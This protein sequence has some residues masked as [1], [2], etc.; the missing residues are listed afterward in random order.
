MEN[1]KETGGY[2]K[3]FKIVLIVLS[4]F[5]AVKMLFFAFG[6][7]EEY[8]LVMAY[9]HIK[10]DKLFLDM[11][12]PHQSSAFLCELLMRPYL[13]VCGK[14]GV[15]IW[16]RF[17]GTLIHL[18]MSVYLC[19][20][21]RRM[22]G[23]DSAF[24]L[25]LIYF[26]TIPKQIMLP[27][28]GIMQV[29]FL[30]LLSLFLIRY[31]DMNAINEGE[32]VD[33]DGTGI[34]T[35]IGGVS[36]AGEGIS[37]G[38]GG[39]GIDGTGIGADV[40]GVSAAGSC[41]G[42]KMY[43]IFAA[44]ALVLEVLSYPSCLIL[45]FFV[46]WILWK[47]SG[48]ER[49]ADMGIF[50]GICAGCGIAYLGLLLRHNTVEGLIGTLSYIVGGDITHSLSF[51]DKFVSLGRDLLVPIGLGVGI[52]VLARAGA[53]VTG[54]WRKARG[55]EKGKEPEG[56]TEIGK[57][58][59]EPEEGTET[60][61]G[62][63]KAEEAGRTG[64]SAI[65]EK[66]RCLRLIWTVVLSCLVEIWYWVVFNAGYEGMQIHLAVFA[67][68]GISCYVSAMKKE[69]IQRT[70]KQACRKERKTG[71]R[72]AGKIET[73][74]IKGD[75][76]G[77][78]GGGEEAAVIKRAMQRGLLLD[79]MILAAG[80]LIAVV[81]LT[82]LGF[83]DSLPHAMTAAFFGMT[84]VIMY[85]EE[86]G[87]AD[88]GSGDLIDGAN[89]NTGGRAVGKRSNHTACISVVLLL[90]TFT[91]VFG[92]GYTLRSGTGYHNVLQSGGILK[93][94]PAAG[95]IS[96]YMCAYIY[97]CDYEDWQNMIRDGDRVLI[98]VDQVMNLGTIQYLFK[99]VEIS[100]YSIVNPTAY[101]ERLLA[102]WEKF[103]G[104]QPNVIIVD[105]WYG[106]LMTDP[107]GWL[108][109]YA[110]GE[111]GYTSMEEGRYIRIYRKE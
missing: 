35:A 1:R 65:T 95:T 82:D 80:A 94:G 102:Y 40:R 92:K 86:R 63:K 90:W 32:D 45:Y 52:F 74:C 97:N 100:H 39:D 89:E 48:K 107:D 64:K 16:L 25:G 36:T 27:E 37:A 42:R 78:A 87:N 76:T 2:F 38:I 55:G 110:E 51:A 72:E 54:R 58:D 57:E 61:K 53:A 4:I 41:I 77:E 31:Y 33:A 47:R 93:Y 99:D 5:A 12:E 105:D 69:G 18:G 75:K 106:Q 81:Y 68:L 88:W 56:G 62:E 23:K 15:V 49:F 71:N 50:T 34:S 79:Q 29:W 70:L 73:E 30:T 7:D 67:A 3:K 11:W 19:R 20:T 8:Q 9:R 103:P 6:L 22:I 66:R 44:F 98:M 85:W 10:G 108:M 109:R 28:F 111:F 17:C 24:L 59:G 96:D 46:M 84:L 14:T 91:A 13:A 104:K 83:M 26:N 60:V 101:D 43:L 21:L